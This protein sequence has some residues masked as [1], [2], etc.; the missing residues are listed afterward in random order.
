MPKSGASEV[1]TFAKLH[2]RDEAL[3]NAAGDSGDSLGL[4]QNGTPR[5]PYEYVYIYIERERALL[6]GENGDQP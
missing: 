5:Y 4:S 1:W 3:L 2:F 6:N